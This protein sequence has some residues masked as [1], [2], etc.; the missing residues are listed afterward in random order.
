MEV[1]TQFFH[2][3]KRMSTTPTW[4]QRLFLRTARID[5]EFPKNNSFS[6][7]Q[8]KKVLALLEASLTFILFNNIDLLTL[9]TQNISKLYLFPR[10]PL[11]SNKIRFN[12]SS[13]KLFIIFK[14]I[15]APWP[16]SIIIYPFEAKET[17]L[18]LLES[19]LIIVDMNNLTTS[20]HMIMPLLSI[21][22]TRLH[23]IQFT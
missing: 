13:F 8:K 6:G 7:S 11:S 5:T 20:W 17:T 18:E 9:Y 3:N 19:Y 22:E 23:H 2:G 1:A 16:P 4:W 15:I 10:S 21:S 14:N 12:F